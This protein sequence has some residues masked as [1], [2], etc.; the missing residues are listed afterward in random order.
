MTSTL[1]PQSS[2]HPV[3]GAFAQP[4][5]G[6]AIA[7]VIQ[8]RDTQITAQVSAAVAAPT[9]G[10]D[11]ATVTPGTAGLWEITGSVSIAGTTVGATDSNNMNLKQTAT[12]K[13]TAI[14]IGVQS[15]TGSNGAVPFGPL[16][17]NLSATDTV[18][19]TAIASATGSSIYA[20][21]INCKLVG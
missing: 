2:A 9:A 5:P 6:V 13:Y 11:V 21:Q 8:Y 4:S 10:T 3:S 19:V 17:L 1:Q 7:G 20:A 18:H 16:T 15:T 12:T 14:P